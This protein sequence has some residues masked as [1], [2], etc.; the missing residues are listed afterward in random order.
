[1]R[2]KFISIFCIG[3]LTITLMSNLDS[4]NS[5]ELED[6]SVSSKTLDSF[7]LVYKK[8]ALLN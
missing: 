1:M 5:L 3:I 6:T 4:I 7:E 2:T 8:H